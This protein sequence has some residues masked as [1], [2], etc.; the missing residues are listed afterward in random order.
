MGHGQRWE[1]DG[2]KDGKKMG[3]R[4]EKDGMKHMKPAKK[5]YPNLITI[6]Y[7]SMFSTIITIDMS[8][9]V[10]IEYIEI[11]AM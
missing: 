2:K 1:K 3:K 8:S 7:G 9:N 4:W 5:N 6:E 10:T 11:I